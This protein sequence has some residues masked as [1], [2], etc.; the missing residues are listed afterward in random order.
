MSSMN[1]SIFCLLLAV[2]IVPS[3][4]CIALSIGGRAR[5]EP[6]LAHEIGELKKLRDRGTITNR[7]FEMGKMALLQRYPGDAPDTTAAAETQLA[8]YPK[9][10]ADVTR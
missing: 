10:V 1:R 7:E 2:A 4:G 6:T 5:Q 3:S 8:T 9:P